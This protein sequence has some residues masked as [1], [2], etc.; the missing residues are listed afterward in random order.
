M[1]AAAQFTRSRLTADLTN[2]TFRVEVCSVKGV[3]NCTTFSPVDGT[4][5]LASGTHF[6]FGSITTP[7]GTQ[8]SIAQASSITLNSRGIPVDNSGAPTGVNALYLTNDAQEYAAVTI[9]ASSNV[10][11][12]K[13]LNGSWV[14]L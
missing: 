11:L 2:G 3:T 8:A 9:S 4:R 7:A 12:W 13:Y 10:S 1:Q 6:G 5:Q 14:R